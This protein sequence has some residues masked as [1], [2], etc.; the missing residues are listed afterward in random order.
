MGNAGC[1]CGC[2]GKGT[3]DTK[4][5]GQSKPDQKEKK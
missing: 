5:T 2:L 3:K 4:E 1:G